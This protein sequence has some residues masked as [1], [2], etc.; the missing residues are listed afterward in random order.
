[1]TIQVQKFDTSKKR[2]IKFLEALTCDDTWFN[3]SFSCPLADVE[4]REPTELP[5]SYV[6][7][8]IE[9]S[10]GEIAGYV[11]IT[12]HPRLR[13][14]TLTAAASRAFTNVSFK[15][16]GSK[17]MAS[18]I[19]DAEASGNVD[20][21]LIDRASPPGLGLYKKFGFAVYGGI[22]G[23]LVR[24]V[25]GRFQIL[26]PNMWRAWDLEWKEQAN[27]FYVANGQYGRRGRKSTVGYRKSRDTEDFRKR[28]FGTA[29]PS[30]NNVP[31]MIVPEK[32]IKE[33]RPYPDWAY[34]HSPK[35]AWPF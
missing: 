8:A 10:R 15:G 26:H 11:T 12:D 6:F 3:D 28:F 17:M 19:R 1:M 22:A 16:V 4:G 34:A 32:M 27:K 31:S 13:L 33:I 35:S 21:V 14:W 2:D 23:T 24:A 5:S 25:S 29:D 20:F 18:M 7:V 30:S 9:T